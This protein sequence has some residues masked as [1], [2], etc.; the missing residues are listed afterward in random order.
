MTYM[1]DWARVF[2]TRVSSVYGFVIFPFPLVSVRADSKSLSV[3]ILRHASSDCRGPGKG[4]GNPGGQVYLSSI[5]ETW[6]VGYQR[7]DVKEYIQYSI[8]QVGGI[9]GSS[10]NGL[11]RGRSGPDPEAWDGDM[12]TVRHR[13]SRQR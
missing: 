8:R 13:R 7:L 3:C 12:V 6:T 1:A 11:R 10:T 9:D 4:C 2:A 5:D